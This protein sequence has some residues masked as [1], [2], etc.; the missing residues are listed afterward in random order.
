MSIFHIITCSGGFYRI[1]FSIFSFFLFGLSIQACDSVDRASDDSVLVPEGYT[2]VFEDTFEDPELNSDYWT[3]GLRD[4]ETGNI[5]PGAHG[6]HLLN[7]NYDSYYTRE[8]TYIEDNRLVLRN[9]RRSYEGSCPEGSYEYTS[10]WVMSMHKVYFNKGYFEFRAKFPAGD[11]VWPALWL[12]PESLTWPPE[13]DMFEYFGYRQDVG[14]DIM[15]LHLAIRP[16][17]DVVWNDYWIHDFHEK[18]DQDEWHIYGFEWT[19]EGAN[20]LINGELVHTLDASEVILYPDE[21]MYIVMNNGTRTRS[22]DENTVWPNYLEIDY[23]RVY[24][25]Q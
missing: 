18:Y 16:E 20:W 8:D 19:E 11:K 9:Q 13:W 4:P 21:E 14:Y 22:P 5:V 12:I 6:D 17:Q 3:F 25:R 1:Y 23:V 24:Q 7:R 2:L 10:G 15:G